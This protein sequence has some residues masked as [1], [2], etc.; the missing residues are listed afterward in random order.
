M[1]MSPSA[2][3]ARFKYMRDGGAMVGTG[4]SKSLNVLNNSHLDGTADGDPIYSGLQPYE[5]ARAPAF[6]PQDFIHGVRMHNA[7]N[8]DWGLDVAESGGSIGVTPD[9]GAS[10]TIFVTPNQLFLQG[11]VNTR[12]YTAKVNGN[13]AADKLTP[14]AV[15]GDMITMLSNSWNDEDWQDPGLRSDDASIFGGGALY[16]PY[17]DPDIELDKYITAASSTTYNTSIVTHNQPTTM[18]GVR[19]GEAAS[20]TSVMQYLEDWTNQDMSFKGSLV[21]MDSRRYTRSY[22]LDI[23]KDYGLSPLGTLGWHQG[24]RY[25][26]DAFNANPSSDTLHWN[27]DINPVYA[28]PNRIFDFN[29]DLLT[30]AGTPPFTPFGVTSTGTGAWVRVL[31]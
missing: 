25:H 27:G 7:A 6:K 4:V 13:N 14:F 28:A 20:I 8:I 19:N 23:I 12:T 24:E 21:V 31:K 9:F 2:R 15:V 16:R 22:L 3:A 1:A 29:E 18:E 5:V 30:E 17:A 10:K 11:D 26:E